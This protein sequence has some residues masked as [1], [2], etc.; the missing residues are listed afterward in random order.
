MQ[1]SAAFVLGAA[2]GYKQNIKLPNGLIQKIAHR[3][4]IDA[5]LIKKAYLEKVAVNWGALMLGGGLGVGG[6]ALARRLLGGGALSYGP[7]MATKDVGDLAA[8]NMAN[9]SHLQGIKGS[10][11]PPESPFGKASSLSKESGDKVA[12]FWSGAGTGAGIGAA[13]GSFIPGVGTAL[14]AGLGGLAGGVHGWLAGDKEN[15][16]PAADGTDTPLAQG[17]QKNFKQIGQLASQNMQNSSYLQGI[18]GAFAP[19]PNPWGGGAN[20]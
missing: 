10:F 7:S 14:G 20:Q 11:A 2:G 3:T 12:G 8:R 13:A 16:T 1:K 4:K 5:R 18:R 6:L 17:P 19:A 9:S 15:P